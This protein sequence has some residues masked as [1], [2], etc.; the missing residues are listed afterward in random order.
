M[1]NTHDTTIESQEDDD[2]VSIQGDL[3]AFSADPANHDLLEQYGHEDEIILA[4]S[5]I[6]EALGQTQVDFASAANMSQ[7]NISRIERA[8]D[9]KFSTIERLARTAGAQIELSAILPDGTRIELMRPANRPAMTAL[10]ATSRPT[11]PAIG[12]SSP[13]FAMADETGARRRGR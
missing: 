9:V 12:Y 2:F 8:L 10:P 13:A 11:P 7:E 6:R 3:D 1:S 4:L 5:N